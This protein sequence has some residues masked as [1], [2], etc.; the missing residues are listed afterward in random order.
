MKRRENNLRRHGSNYT[1]EWYTPRHITAAL[2]H[3]DLDP[4]AG[5]STRH[6]RRNIRRPRCGLASDWKGR[7]WLN[8]PYSTMMPWLEKLVAHGDGI[9]LVNARMETGWF[10]RLV[11]HAAGILL[12]KGRI[13]FE[14]P[15]G[16]NSPPIGSALVAF[17][18]ENFKALKRS[19]IE[20]LVFR[21]A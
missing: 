4:C 15:K 6:A 19:K 17:G 3:F 9:A 21:T 7:I 1:D 2:G 8:P 16:K 14:G 20:G 18:D 5:P 11:S 12:P 10:Q 13:V